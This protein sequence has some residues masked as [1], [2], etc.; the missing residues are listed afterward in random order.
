MIIK[1]HQQVSDTQSYLE[2]NKIEPRP[3]DSK[4]VLSGALSDG[5][6]A[7][8]SP[9]GGF[10]FEGFV[11]ADFSADDLRR[12]AESWAKVILDGSDQQSLFARG[13]VNHGSHSEAQKEVDRGD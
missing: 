9:Y 1:L 8:K 5:A 12:V 3:S 7:P 4:A 2:G 10:I 11:G 13:L 6:P